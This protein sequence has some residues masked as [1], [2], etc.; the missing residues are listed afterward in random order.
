[1]TASH[2]PADPY[3]RRNLQDWVLAHLIGS[4]PC[5][6]HLNPIP[7]VSDSVFDAVGLGM[8]SIRR[9]SRHYKPRLFIV[10]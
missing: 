2:L 6:G 9:S 8:A 1:M 4:D 7:V 10:H 3:T 5:A